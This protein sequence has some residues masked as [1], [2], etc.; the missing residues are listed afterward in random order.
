MTAVLASLRGLVRR[1]G[2][3]TA[4]AGADL[5]VRRGEVHGV[6]GE[7]GAGK[8]T[9]LGVLGGMTRPD[10]GVVEISGEVVE[11]SG[12]RAAWRCGVGLVHQH[13]TLVPALTVLENLSLGRGV[14]VSGLALPLA[15]VRE[16]AEHLMGRTGL[17]VS[18]D[19]RVE[20]L[21]VGD[22]QRVEIL[23]ALLREP[24]LL[25][26]DEPTAVLTPGEV[27]SLFSLLRELAADGTAVVL[28]AHKI[29][30]VLSVA[31]RVTVLRRGRTVMTAERAAVDAP[32]LVRA[33]VGDEAPDSAVREL[34]GPTRRGVEGSAARTVSRR[35]AREAVAWLEDVHVRRESGGSSLSGASL[36]VGRGEIVGIAG[37]EGNGQRELALV[38]AGR[39]R[40]ESGA[41]HV[42]EGV[43]FIS[44]DR[45]G[46]GVIADF[47]LV[48]NV[49]LAFHDDPD[50]GRGAV[51]G[52]SRIREEARG[53]VS[54]FGV[55]TPGVEALAGTLSGGNQQRLVVGRELLRARDLLVAENPTR[56]L[57]VAATAFVHSEL[58]RIV[59]AADGPGVVLISTDLDE[60]L[61]L[62]GRVLVLS[63]GRLVEAPERAR[64]REGIGA[65]M[66]GGAGAD[67]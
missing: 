4:L 40:P 11:L 10:A 30:E 54:R 65:L 44:Q 5:E 3:V 21:G 15:R 50:I 6:L 20:D 37:V 22:R 27:D 16:D 32:T 58:Q 48:E 38:L 53:V 47:D 45:T 57:D 31:D 13:F 49:A 24:P 1:F 8:T 34:E 35:P 66:L 56:G 25:V 41:T 43:G 12:P 29:E 62:C 14:G 28:V 2:P 42:P 51:L 18:L 19:E 55:V 36:S 26:L 52:W 63:G 64:T 9:L 7:N 17:R 67:G 33:M 39:S 59:S 23:K 61:R 60:I 46:E